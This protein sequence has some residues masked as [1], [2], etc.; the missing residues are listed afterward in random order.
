MSRVSRVFLHSLNS[1]LASE[2]KDTG[3]SFDRR[4]ARGL[5]Q[6]PCAYDSAVIFHRQRLPNSWIRQ[7]SARARARVR[8][9]SDNYA[10]RPHAECLRAVSRIRY[11]KRGKKLKFATITTGLTSSITYKRTWMHS[12]PCSLSARASA[13]VRRVNLFCSLRE[14]LAPC[15][16]ARVVLLTGSLGLTSEKWI[17]NRSTFIR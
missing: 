1:F 15:L 14:N 5:S 4:A 13:K 2:Q 10:P 9:R 8:R 3:P 12:V 16:I 7:I 6:R 17:V 11:W